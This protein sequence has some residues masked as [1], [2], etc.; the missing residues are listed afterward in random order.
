MQYRTFGR[1]GWSVSE[2]GYGMWGMG[3]W[4]GSDDDESMA[5]LH[6]AV[7][8]GCNFFDTAW[9]YGAGHSE[10]LLGRRTLA[11][12][13]FFGIARWADFHQAVDRRD[14]PG[15]DRLYETLKADAGV[16][17]ALAIEHGEEAKSSG[18]FAGHVT[19]EEALAEMK[20]AA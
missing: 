3:G 18:G 11:D 9:G 15:L 19:L 12:A 1:T 6:R 4:T 20:E 14:Y 13:Y 10:G 16:R 2:I 8:L 17:F 5:S 7:E